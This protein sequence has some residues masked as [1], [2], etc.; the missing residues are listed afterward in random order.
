MSKE[1]FNISKIDNSISIYNFKSENYEKIRTLCSGNFGKVLLV[2]KLTSKN[3]A[4]S[5]NFALKINRRIELN[6]GK[7]NQGVNEPKKEKDKNVKKNKEIT[8]IELVEMCN[9]KKLSHHPNIV[10]I[11]DI[12]FSNEE[13][14]ILMEYVPTDIRKFFWKNKNNKKYMNERFFKSIA[15][16][17]ICGVNFIHSE[18]VVHRDLKPENI[19]YD[20][21]NNIVKIG[22]FG[23]SVNLDFNPESDY[24]SAGTYPYMPPDAILGLKKYGN[25]FDIWS[26]GCVLFEICTISR[27]IDC[28]PDDTAEVVLQL[29]YNIFGSFNDNTLRGYKYFP[30]SYYLNNLKETKGI[31]LNNLIKEKKKF[32]FENDNFFDLIGKMLCIDPTKR[33]SA[34]DCLSHPWF[35][36]LKK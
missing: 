12:N 1:I 19:F 14:W 13:S 11:I 7:E 3:L 35:G 30:R 5:I 22:D 2:K 24:L 29:M 34:K 25:T 27:L 36:D 20:D 32:E 33:I 16:Q 15:Y 28:K 10:N 6:T 31:G 26:V 21:K 23:L 17:I 8:D 9:L 4:D 18:L